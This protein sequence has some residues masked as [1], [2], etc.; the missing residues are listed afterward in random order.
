MFVSEVVIYDIDEI[1]G[2]Y[3]DIDVKGYGGIIFL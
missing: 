2:I 1:N 3:F